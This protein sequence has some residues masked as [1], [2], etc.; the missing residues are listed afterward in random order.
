MLT[1]YC[2]KFFLAYNKNIDTLIDGLKLKRLKHQ[3]RIT[4][5]INGRRKNDFINDCLKRN[6]HES[7][8]AKNV[9]E[10]YYTIMD[11]RPELKEKEFSEIKQYLIKAVSEPP[12]KTTSHKP[13]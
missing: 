2:N 1:L 4:T 12:H 9:V 5:F 3:I 6:L 8:V 11:L 13:I 7:N 10:L